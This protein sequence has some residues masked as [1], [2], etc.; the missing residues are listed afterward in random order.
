MLDRK[1]QITNGFVFLAGA[2]PVALVFALIAG[3]TVGVIAFFF[4]ILLSLV[5]FLSL[6]NVENKNRF[7]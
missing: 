2:F 1:Q 5:S 6:L 4:C 3:I 7:H